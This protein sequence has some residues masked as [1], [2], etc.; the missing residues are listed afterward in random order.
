MGEDEEFDRRPADRIR[1]FTTSHRVIRPGEPESDVHEVEFYLEA[2]AG[3][4]YPALIRRTDPTRNELPDGGG[5]VEVVARRIAGLDFEYFDGE[6]WSPDW[7]GFLNRSP[8]TLRITVAVADDE[9]ARTARP[10][11]RLIHLPMMPQPGS[12]GG[13]GGGTEDGGASVSPGGGFGTPSSG[14]GGL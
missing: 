13:S 1:F 10:Y 3:E 14:G 9:A 6:R 11:R 8:S 2:Q 4:P 12:G 5:V 7:P